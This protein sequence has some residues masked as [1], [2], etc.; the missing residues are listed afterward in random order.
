[1]TQNYEGK[2]EDGKWEPFGWDDA[3]EPTPESTGYEE[4]RKV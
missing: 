3:V 1:M 4:V 2:R